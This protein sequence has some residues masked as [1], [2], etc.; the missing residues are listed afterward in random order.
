MAKHLVGLKVAAILVFISLAQKS[1]NVHCLVTSDHS[2][3]LLI[4]FSLELDG[5]RLRKF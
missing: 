3:A 4:A 1:S 5:V 2:I